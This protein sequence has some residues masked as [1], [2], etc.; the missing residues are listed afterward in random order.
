LNAVDSS[1]VV[2]AFASWHES[3][4]SARRAVDRRPRLVAHCALEAYSVLTRL[5]APYRAPGELVVTFLDDR[6]PEEPLT[7]VP[8]ALQQLA[9]E[10]Q[11]AGIVGGAVYDG[12]VA[13]TAAAHRATLLTLDRRAETT[14]R[15]CG[16]RARFL[17]GTTG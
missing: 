1:V 7:L 12:L 13:V 5:P 15:R 10:L 8:R 9:G 4:A 16:L 17:D 6:F 14:Y 3:H 11:R 2:A